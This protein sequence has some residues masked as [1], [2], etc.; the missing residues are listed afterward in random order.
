MSDVY[1][2]LQRHLDRLPMGF[3]RSKSGVE[4]EILRK[5]FTPEEA[6]IAC[7]LEV[8]PE[9]PEALAERLGRDPE[10]F[11]DKLMEMS[12][13]GLI[14]R[15]KRNGETVFSGAPFVVG[16]YEYQIRKMDRDLASKKDRYLRE[17]FSEEWHRG[18]KKS[19]FLRVVP[20][21]RSIK[22]DM[23][24]QPYEVMRDIIRQQEL[25]A[26][27]DCICRV[28][29]GLLDHPCEKPVETCFAFGAGAQ[30]YIENG[31]GREVSTDEALD[32]LEQCEEAGL[33]LSPSNSQAPAGMCACCSCCCDVLKSLKRFDRPGLVAQSAFYSRVDPELCQACGACVERC[34]ME[35]VKLS[36]SAAAVSADHCI[37]CGVCV[38]ACP[39]EAIT[40]HRRA[41]VE[42]P[43]ERI[44]ALFKKMAAEREKA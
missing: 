38:G 27:T 13:K 6:E 24:A 34:P 8:R 17:A 20:V 42:P 31:W 14:F 40:L 32:I 10:A 22:P 30:F 37:G 35:A 15:S 16:I 3:P 36:E 19:S 18:E 11:G 39:A 4:I 9:K 5:L 26:V 7:E 2:R 33:V 21:N 44:G 41:A 29:A 1:E 25:V 23:G 12:N 43:P 28:K